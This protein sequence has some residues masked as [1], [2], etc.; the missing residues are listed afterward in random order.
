M[1][2]VETEQKEWAF[3]VKEDEMSER[4]TFC[5]GGVNLKMLVDSGATS[6]VMGEN[7]WNRLKAENIKCY[8]YVPKEQ[9]MFVSIFIQSVTAS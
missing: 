2:T 6:N 1:N 7:V 5:V 9:K 3:I 8:S 4:L